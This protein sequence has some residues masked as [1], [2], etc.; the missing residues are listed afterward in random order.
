MSAIPRVV[1]AGGKA[2]GELAHQIQCSSRALAVFQGRR[3][4]DIV[5]EALVRADADARVTVV[6]DVPDSAAYLRVGDQ[7]DFVSNL[8]A[9]I[10]ASGESDW[11][12]ISSS[13]M[14]Y[15]DVGPVVEFVRLAI[16]RAAATGADLV[17]P[18]VP[19]S[20]CYA[21]YPRLSRTA[22]KLR[23]GEYTGGNMMIARPA[24]LVKRRELISR[25]YA[26]RKQP[27][28]LAGMLG[29]QIV[30]RLA[31]SQLVAPAALNLDMLERRV[32]TLCGGR[33]VALACELPEIATDLDKPSDFAIA[34]QGSMDWSSGS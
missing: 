29:L 27:F 19:V 15:L 5:V 28:R 2:T 1:L 24:F 3:L 22:V 7:G 10:A 16:A 11:I 9:G 20:S 8:Y 6:G 12:L 31:V 4:L 21:R 18:I 14:P 30:I 23:E 33:V 34:T 25:A 26:A 13:D 17:Y 32:G